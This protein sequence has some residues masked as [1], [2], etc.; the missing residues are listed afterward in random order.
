[1]IFA[2]GSMYPLIMIYKKQIVKEII[3]L[4]FSLEKRTNLEYDE[5]TITYRNNYSFH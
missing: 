3:N 1:M 5:N 2:H 4:I